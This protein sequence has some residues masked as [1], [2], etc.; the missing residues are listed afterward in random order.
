MREWLRGIREWFKARIRVTEQAQ[1]AATQTETPSTGL[2]KSGPIGWLS[3]LG[4]ALGATRNAALNWLVSVASIVIAIAF[5]GE[6]FNTAPIIHPV[7]LPDA[8]TKLGYTQEGMAAAVRAETRRLRD[9][10][11]NGGG[12]T[13]RHTPTLRSGDVQLDLQVPGAPVS[14]RTIVRWVHAQLG[15]PESRIVSEVHCKRVVTGLHTSSAGNNAKRPD[16]ECDALDLSVDVVIFDAEGQGTIHRE[17]LEAVPADKIASRMAR[18]IAHYFTPAVLGDVLLQEANEAVLRCQPGVFDAAHRAFEHAI[19]L[20]ER[21]RRL[22]ERW[23]DTRGDELWEQGQLGVVSVMQSRADSLRTPGALQDADGIAS[24]VIAKRPHSAMALVAKANTLFRLARG[25]EALAMFDKAQGLEPRNSEVYAS[26]AYVLYFLADFKG[27][28]ENNEHALR[29]SP[30]LPVL[31]ANLGYSLLKRDKLDEAI[32]AFKAATRRD[33]EHGEWAGLGEAMRRQKKHDQAIEMLGRAIKE[34]P[35][36]VGAVISM[37]RANLE[38][39]R[40]KAALVYAE[41]LKAEH[42]GSFA[43]IY[44]IKAKAL[45]VLGR[46]NESTANYERA[47]RLLNSGSAFDVTDVAGSIYEEYATKLR[48]KDVK[49]AEAVLREG[50]KANNGNK[51]LLGRLQNDVAIA[52]ADQGR[53]ADAEVELLKALEFDK[54]SA[55][56]YANLAFVRERLHHDNDALDAARRAIE[57]DP[58][59]GVA[60]CSKGKVLKRRNQREE[61]QAAVKKAVELGWECSPDS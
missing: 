29:E 60:W 17:T 55:R 44:Q 56:V 16:G 51:P 58:K 10:V 20:G 61:A 53:D 45:E 39:N 21:P 26:R 32:I 42:G 4:E 36:D 12:R 46:N 40:P 13:A 59:E 14:L 24:E 28:V 27:A 31:Y 11:A 41:Q 49:K 3:Q 54:D 2:S 47:I 19:R 7:G 23:T 43:E 50:I 34:R 8:L 18:V 9:I 25:S 48:G 33:P 52:L 57:L 22:A 38:A 5:V 1:S 6:I 35:C 15:L 37:A 30:G